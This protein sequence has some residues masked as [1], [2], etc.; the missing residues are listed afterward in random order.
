MKR[1][2]LKLYFMLFKMSV[3]VV[4]YLYNRKS[5]KYYHY[6][7]AKNGIKFSGRPH[8]IGLT[9]MFDTH[10]TITIGKGVV[11]SEEVV[12]LTHEWVEQKVKLHEQVPLTHRHEM[13]KIK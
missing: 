2:L 6:F 4:H 8:F 9:S 11:I 1:L 12:F 10:G 3:V 13:I 7:L 5:Q